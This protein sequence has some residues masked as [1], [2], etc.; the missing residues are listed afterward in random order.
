MATTS[1]FDP[2][3]VDPEFYS[4][5]PNQHGDSDYGRESEGVG[6]NAYKDSTSGMDM[7]TENRN[8]TAESRE[9]NKNVGKP[10][11]PV[12]EKYGTTQAWD[13]DADAVNDSGQPKGHMMSDEAAKKLDEVA[14]NPSDDALFH[15][16]DA[17]YLEDGDNPGE[18]YDPHNKG[19]DGKDKTDSQ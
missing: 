16:G 5:D 9:D 14:E 4:Q 3:K 12:G 8:M 1:P 15:R 11:L 6:T 18:G 17:T 10:D 13:V 2:D 19:Y 7:E